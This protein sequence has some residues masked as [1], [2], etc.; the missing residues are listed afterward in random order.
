MRSLVLVVLL[1]LS[2]FA[3]AED[4]NVEKLTV[5]QSLCM[6]FKIFGVQWASDSSFFP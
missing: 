3:H 2:F 6:G 1:Q 4:P 5:N